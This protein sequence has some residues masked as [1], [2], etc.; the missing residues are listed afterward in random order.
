MTEHVVAVLGTRYPDL[1][2]EE[3]ILGPLGV[4]LVTGDGG[5]EATIVDNMPYRYRPQVADWF[6]DVLGG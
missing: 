4:R 2:V 3:G 1:S 6:V 5:S